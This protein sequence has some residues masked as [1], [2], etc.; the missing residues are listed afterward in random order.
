M[1]HRHNLRCLRCGR[2]TVDSEKRKQGVRYSRKDSDISLG[3][4]TI[5][6]RIVPLDVRVK[7][8]YCTSW[9]E[10]DVS[11]PTWKY[12]EAEMEADVFNFRIGTY[13]SPSLIVDMTTI[14]EESKM[15]RKNEEGIILDNYDDMA[16]LQVLK[17]DKFE[18]VRRS[19][20][21][22][23]FFGDMKAEWNKTK[24]SGVSG[25]SRSDSIAL[26]S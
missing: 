25:T 15:R 8:Q 18:K 6:F 26:E 21:S 13:P 5:T 12:D 17:K 11:D 1:R 9:R 23:K 16:L 7:S 22:A 20:D 24:R 2:I 4:R 10:A 3:E 19:F 14:W